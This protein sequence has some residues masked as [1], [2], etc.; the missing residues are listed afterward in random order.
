MSEDSRSC[1]SCGAHVSPDAS[2]CDLCGT[3][4]E[5]ADAPDPP[6]TD[7]EKE[8]ADGSEEDASPETAPASGSGAEEAPVEQVYCHDCG[9]ENP[10]GA[11]YCS[12]CGTELQDVSDDEPAGARPVEADLPTGAEASAEDS[13]AEEEISDEQAE[14]GR[15]ILLVVGTAVVLVLGLFF[16]TQW[17]QQ[18]EWG[19]ADES[20]PPA[21]AERQSGESSP[22]ASPPS[23]AGATGSSGPSSTPEPAASPSTP[24]GLQTLVDQFGGSVAGA[25]ASQVDSLRTLVDGA[26]GDEQR[27]LRSKLA[28]LYVGA[29]APGQAALVQSK[30]A[31][32][33]GRVED[34]RRV[35]N[36][37]Y[38]WMR[39]VE[40]EQGR[41]Q[42]ADVARHVAEAYAAVV[43]QR[44]E[45]LDARTRMGEAYLLTN[46]PMKGIRAINQVL[47]DDSTFVPAR[48]QKGLA[49]LQINRLDQA[50]AQFE[51]VMTHASQD[52][53]F[54][55][56]AKKAIE[57]IRKQAESSGS[58]Q[59]DG[60]RSS[61]DS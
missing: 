6:A 30:V 55:Q 23:G 50:V 11:N 45:D 53:P 24:E 4:I 60:S 59:S 22:N 47:E 9:W 58:G 36:L 21:A 49:L 19:S 54:Y 35:A 57:V 42:V 25:M 48:F 2:V 7:A 5:E 29:G 15:Q 20:T 18:Y 17:S 41:A 37:L 56:Q 28:Q 12:R 8:A 33:S 13:A 51:K 40:Q 32:Q 44:P 10:P 31:E 16:A 3:P 61:M 39:K 43:E 52:D 27:Q 38:K 26:S 1:P 46:N 14:M 34:R